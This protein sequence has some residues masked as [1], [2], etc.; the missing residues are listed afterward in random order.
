LRQFEK[1]LSRLFVPLIAVLILTGGTMALAAQES[2]APRPGEICLGCDRPVESTDLLLIHRGR[3]VP[4]HQGPCFDAWG[5][6]PEAMFASLQP[7]GALFQEPE[8]SI[9]PLRDA[10]FAFGA[11]VL[12]GLIFG[13]A[14]AYTA[15][16]R[17][18]APLRW[19]VA[20]LVVNALAL[21][22]LLARPRAD[23]SKLPA[24]VPPGLRKVPTTRAGVPCPKCC[25]LNHPAA[26]RCAACG[27]ALQPSVA[28]ETARV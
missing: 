5:R 12:L 4:L 23:L 18:H 24:G 9:S 8:G 20:G 28:A 21:V 2:R 14:C 26:R 19:F 6:N 7:R 13:A 1:M 25:S 10:W 15:V 17:G 3:R 11:Y 22:V 16:G 27:A